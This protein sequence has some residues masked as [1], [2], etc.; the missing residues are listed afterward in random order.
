MGR[1]VCP[2]CNLKLVDTIND[3][4]TECNGNLYLA[5]NPYDVEVRGDNRD[6][7]QCDGYREF[8]KHDI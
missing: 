3:P 7:L 2:Y 1:N 5:P 8:S 6:K 4:N